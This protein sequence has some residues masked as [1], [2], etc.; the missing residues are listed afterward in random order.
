MPFADIR[1]ISDTPWEPN[2]YD[3]TLAAARGAAVVRY[4]ADHLP[5]QVPKAPVTFAGLSKLSAAR[6]AGYLDT[7]K[8]FYDVTQVSQ[9]D[10]ANTAGSN[11]TLTGAALASLLKQYGYGQDG[12]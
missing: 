5:A 1:E 6:Q 9:I 4:L 2:A 7:T 8:A 12:L 10:Y 3:G 11:V